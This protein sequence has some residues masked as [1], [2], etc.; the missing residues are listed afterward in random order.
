MNTITSSQFWD[1]H[2]T[3]HLL[4]SK[5]NQSLCFLFMVLLWL[6]IGLKSAHAQQVSTT[7]NIHLTDVLSIHPESVA[8]GGNVDFNYGSVEDYH[9]GKTVSVPNSLIIT[10]TKP[11]DIKVKA[12]GPNFESGDQSIPVEV[13][14][15]K[16]RQEGN[17]DGNGAPVVLSTQ[18]QVLY[19]SSAAG[20][21]I[22]LGLDY[23]IPRE[24]AS[25]TQ[26]LGKPTGVYSQQVTYTATAL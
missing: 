16:S 3:A 5:E 12:L 22:A 24:K 20:G 25:S 21:K 4:F 8:Q 6:G 15:I 1:N 18:E 23:S 7:I 26:I 14:T 2:N 17:P 13:L 9:S 10:F 19:S 11:F